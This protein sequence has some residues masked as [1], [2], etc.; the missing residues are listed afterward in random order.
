[1]KKLDLLIIVALIFSNAPVFSQGCLPE[2]IS[3]TTQ[4]EIDNFQ[5]NYPGCSEIDGDVYIGDWMWG[6]S[7]TNL[8]GLSVLTS[9]GSSLQIG[10]NPALT[11]LIGLDNLNTIGGDFWIYWNNDLANLTGLENLSSI[12]GIL[13]IDGN[14]I[15]TD[16]VGLSNVSS[17]DSYLQISN[18]YALTSL[19]GLDGLE[20]GSIG[21]LYIFGNIS[22]S[23]CDVQSVCDYLVAPN[24]AIEIYDNAPGCNSP[25]EVQEHCLTDI[26]EQRSE[27]GLTIIPNPSNDK[28]TI[29]ISDGVTIDEVVIYNQTGQ[30][31]LQ[32]KQ[33]NN[34]LDISNLQHGMY[35][36]E[37]ETEQGMIREKLIVQ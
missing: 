24:G 17:I 26:D 15:L 1:M 36:I 18:H 21:D 32:D 16:L 14:N 3:F 23:V 8:N 19:T 27:N 28:I 20:S 30:K 22:L 29:S 2:G 5:T 34:T 13:G 6:S 35:I 4:E 11:S 12:G 31:V 9:V 7:I 10:N 37:L 25:E 33:V